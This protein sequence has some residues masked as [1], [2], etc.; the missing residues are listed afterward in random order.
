MGRPLNAAPARVYLDA[1]VLIGMVEVGKNLSFG[2]LS[3]LARLEAGEVIGVTSELSLTEVMVKPLAGQDAVLAA[4][5]QDLLRSRGAL[6]V[7]PVS[8]DVLLGAAWLRVTT[9]MKLPDAI[10]VATADIAGCAEFVSADRGLRLPDGMQ[11]V[12][13]DRL[14]ERG[15]EEA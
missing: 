6:D 12:I 11:Q 2:Q 5:F 15:L 13:W 3:Y 10:H 8:R 7:V 4:A 9:R 1:N 14:H